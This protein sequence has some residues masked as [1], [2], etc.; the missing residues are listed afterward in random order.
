MRRHTLAGKDPGGGG[1]G[2]QGDDGDLALSYP[3]IFEIFKLC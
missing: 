2:F 1:G 3:L